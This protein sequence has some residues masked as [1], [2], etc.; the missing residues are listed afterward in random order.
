MGT[1]LTRKHTPLGPY[2]MP[3][4][5]V[6]GGSQGGGRFVMSK[7]PLYANCSRCICDHLHPDCGTHETVTA[8]FRPWLEPLLARKPPKPFQLFPFGQPYMSPQHAVEKLLQVLSLCR[9][10]TE[11]TLPTMIRRPYGRQYRMAI[12]VILSIR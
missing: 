3:M 7:A 6:L 2:R 9:A 4:S 12:G 10:R 1:S 8:R 11:P 5:R